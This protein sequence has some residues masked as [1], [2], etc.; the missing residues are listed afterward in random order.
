MKSCVRTP[1]LAMNDQ[2]D[3][4]VNLLNYNQAQLE[5]FVL[6]LGEK[7]YRAKQL[8]KWIH[9]IGETDFD[10]MTNLSKAFRHQLQARTVIE[11]P[12]MISEHISEDG[13]I[14]WLMQLG[15]GNAVETV[16]IPEK[17]RGTLCVSSQIGCSLDCSF[18][19][20][21]KQGF[22]RNLTTAEIIGQLWLAVRRLAI[23]GKVHERVVTNVVMMGMGEPLLNFEPVVSAMD[24][25]LDDSAYNLS[26]YRVTLSTSGVIPAMLELKARTNVALAVSLH[27][28]NDELRNILVPINKKYNINK[29]MDVCRNYFE[30]EPRRAVCF[31][32]VMLNGVND[33]P[34]HAR[35]LI[36]LCANVSCKF[37]LI[38]FNPFPNTQYTCSSNNAIKKFQE[39]LQQAGFVATVR[40]TRGDDIDGACG[41]LAGKF[42][43][44]T[45]RSEKIAKRLKQ[46]ENTQQIE[47][48]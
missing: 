30:D 26:K 1:V 6:E 21:G 28:P 13:T 34:E 36:K 11:P 44:R 18:C 25:M 38:P 14:K 40:S 47:V 12:T 27:A 33:Q 16:F 41:Q 22:N 17:V 8:I 5:A 43:D 37:N 7:P 9:Q 31:E 10:K 15:E 46:V 3:S 48:N 35:Q 24:L 23:S 19:A 42:K 20:T 29:L 2:T 39:I 32:Y 45:R 4:P